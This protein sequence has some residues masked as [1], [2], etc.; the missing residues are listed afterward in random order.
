ML[1]SARVF[2]SKQV[3]TSF[4]DY[5]KVSCRLGEH[6]L[7][8]RQPPSVLL[9]SAG[10]YCKCW[11]WETWQSDWLLQTQEWFVTSGI[12]GR[13]GHCVDTAPGLAPTLGQLLCRPSSLTAPTPAIRLSG[14]LTPSHPSPLTRMDKS[15]WGWFPEE[16]SSVP[17]PGTP[18]EGGPHPHRGWGFITEVRVIMVAGGALVPAFRVVSPDKDL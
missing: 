2:S 4:R 15:S 12:C 3:F 16:G 17:I 7:D 10:V 14:P 9:F 18:V 6:F 1:K 8:H 5:R 11:F 13:C